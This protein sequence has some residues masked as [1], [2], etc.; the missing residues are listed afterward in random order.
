M[1]KKDLSEADICDRYI[2]PALYEAGWKKSQIRREYGFTDGQM[3]VRGQIASRKARKRADYLLYYPSNQPIAVIEAKDNTHSVRAGIQQALAYAKALEVPFVFSS[4]G[5]GF[6]FHDKSGTYAQVEQ[7]LSLDAFPSPEVLWQHYKQGQDLQAVNQDL[8]TS[9]Y[10]IEIG[11]KEPR[12]YQQLAV[13]R[14]IEAMA[15]GQKRCLLVMATGAGKTYTVFNIRL[16]G[17]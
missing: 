14:T 3:I 17:K 13:N 7:Q 8:L 4:N 5:D 15:R 12:Y 6:L 2:T 11:G 16:V 9:P 1:S 10:Y